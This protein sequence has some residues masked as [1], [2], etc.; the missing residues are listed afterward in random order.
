MEGKT[1]AVRRNWSA[2]R[3]GPGR[4]R[5]RAWL[6]LVLP[7]SWVAVVLALEAAMPD[8]IQLTP[9][10][11][12]AP[13]IAC[14]GTGRRQCVLLAGLCALF[15][16]VPL[17]SGAAGQAGPGQ[18]IGTFGAI[19]AV[20]VASYVISRRRLRVLHDVT[21]VWAA[22]DAAQDALLRPHRTEVGN[23]RVAARHASASSGPAIGGAFYEVLDTPYGVR[24]VIG[25]AGAGGLSGLQAVERA[26]AVLGS[27]RE[28]AY[29]EPDLRDVM[30]RLEVSLRRHM[31]RNP[32]QSPDLLRQPGAAAASALLRSAL[33]VDEL[34]Q[35]SD[36]LTRPRT[37]ATDVGPETPVDLAVVSISPDGRLELV[38]HGLPAPLLLHARAV[39]VVEDCRFPFFE[40]PFGVGDSVLLV[41][42]GASSTAAEALSRLVDAPPDEIAARIRSDD[43]ALMVLQRADGC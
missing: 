24:A 18:R 17:G 16:L 23:V 25:D 19:L 37:S 5:A 38:N 4:D 21:Q 14:A 34:W 1:A 3:R 22:A 6:V 41:T 10:L 30:R 15:A 43:L 31:A 26:A 40:V 36:V 9:L 11:A 8:R 27:F 42:D 13:A 32:S 2:S 28:A 35:V 33:D 29:D 39:T 7:G 20:A 12:A